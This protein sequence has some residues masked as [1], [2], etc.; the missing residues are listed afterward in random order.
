MLQKCERQRKGLNQFSVK[1]ADLISLK[2]SRLYVNNTLVCYTFG[3]RQSPFGVIKGSTTI[4]WSLGKA[5]VVQR[6]AEGS[7]SILNKC[8]L[9]EA[10]EGGASHGYRV[11]IIKGDRPLHMLD[12]E[13]DTY[14]L[15]EL[16]AQGSCFELYQWDLWPTLYTL[17][18][19][20]LLWNRPKPCKTNQS[21][22]ILDKWHLQERLFSYLK[23]RS[24]DREPKEKGLL[25]SSL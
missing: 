23:E 5:V 20:L 8:G 15:S 10:V 2:N 14:I 6:G 12:L 4:K 25:L 1:S 3:A 21:E 11:N 9:C 24:K 16:P 17:A 13:P 22:A 7:G 18:L 19:S